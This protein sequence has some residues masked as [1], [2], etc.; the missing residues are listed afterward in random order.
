MLPG[1]RQSP[2]P[3]LP[4]TPRNKPSG[5]FDWTKRTSS[6][7]SPRL[8][9]SPHRR[10]IIRSIIS[11]CARVGGARWLSYYV[12]PVTGWRRNKRTAPLSPSANEIV[13]CGEPPLLLHAASKFAISPAWIIHPLLRSPARSIQDEK[14]VR[15]FVFFVPTA[16]CRVSQIESERGGKKK[17]KF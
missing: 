4:L 17:K 6:L 1:E 5:N 12:P 8:S 14:S 11:T 13:C 15:I 9:D 16:S 3:C 7:P 10:L 2:S